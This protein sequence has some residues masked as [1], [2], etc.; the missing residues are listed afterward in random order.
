MN[1]PGMSFALVS[2]ITK[3]DKDFFMTL[4]NIIMYEAVLREVKLRLECG[5]G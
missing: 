5:S 2:A 3:W 1:L 4:I